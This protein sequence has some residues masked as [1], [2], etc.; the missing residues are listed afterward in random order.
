[1]PISMFSWCKLTNET[2]FLEQ[3]FKRIFNFYKEV[4][5]Q[6]LM[7]CKESAS[8]SDGLQKSWFK[9][10]YCLKFLLKIVFFFHKNVSLRMKFSKTARK[11]QLCR[12][13][14]LRR[15]KKSIFYIEFSNDFWFFTNILP[16]NSDGWQ[17]IDSKS[18]SFRSFRVKKF[19]CSENISLRV[20]L[21][22][23]ARKSQL[24]RF[25]S[26]RRSKKLIF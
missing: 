14:S 1:M 2:E 7:L 6:N 21:S 26:L 3:I 23:T 5:Y 18:D 4:L 12:F 24:C 11:C 20:K 17:N 25:Y 8:K 22:K 19:F 13:Y 10:W 9:I 16:S 15:S